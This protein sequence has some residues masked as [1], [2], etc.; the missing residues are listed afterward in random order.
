MKCTTPLAPGVLPS[1]YILRFQGCMYMQKLC[2]ETDLKACCTIFAGG[3][4]AAAF[5]PSQVEEKGPWQRLADL[6]TNKPRTQSDTTR[7]V[8]E[9]ACSSVH[10]ACT[11]DMLIAVPRQCLG[12]PSFA[13]TLNTACTR[14]WLTTKLCVQSYAQFSRV[15]H[16]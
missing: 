15:Q 3:T 6:T 12:L 8:P 1:Q 13:C 14:H 10:R 7:H 2:F 11:C 16:S 4:L 5:W 9:K